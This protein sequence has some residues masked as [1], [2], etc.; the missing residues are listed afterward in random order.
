MRLHSLVQIYLNAYLSIF[1]FSFRSFL[2]EV[3]VPQELLSKG[4]PNSFLQLFALKIKDRLYPS[5]YLQIKKFCQFKGQSHVLNFS[6]LLNQEP[7]VPWTKS[8]MNNPQRA[9]L[10][11]LQGT[12]EICDCNF[13]EGTSTKDF[14]RIL[15]SLDLRMYQVLCTY[16]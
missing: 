1:L 16:V 3:E 6:M 11:L 10:L 13:Y 5:N 9:K 14:R 15:A 2:L 8:L 7:M 4:L 12:Y